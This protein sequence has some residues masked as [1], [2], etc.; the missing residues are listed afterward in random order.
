M[1]LL[2][3]TV[4]VRSVPSVRPLLPIWR[5]KKATWDERKTVECLPHDSETRFLGWEDALEKGKATHS[6]ILA[7]RIPWLN[8]PWSRKESELLSDFHFH[9]V[10]TFSPK[11]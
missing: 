4:T 7:W 9:S 11:L 8:S 10:K 6:S 1:G 3:R 2:L 5:E